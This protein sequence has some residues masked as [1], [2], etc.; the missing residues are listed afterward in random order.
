[1]TRHFSLIAS[2]LLT[3]LAVLAAK[4]APRP[5]SPAEGAVVYAPHPHFRWLRE[6][7]VKIDEVHCV[8]IARDEAFAEVVCEDHLEVVSR[9]VPVTALPPARYWW[10]VRRGDGDWSRATGFEVRAPGKTFTVRAGS[11]GETV[12]RMLLEAVKNAP[13]RVDFEPGEYAFSPDAGESLVTMTNARDL[14]I[15]GHGAHLVLAGTFLNLND[16]QRVTVQ[17]FRLTASRPGHTL[18]RVVKKDPDAMNLTVL[19]EPGHAPDVT[20]YFQYPGTAGSFLGC[21]DPVHHGKYIVGAFVSARNTQCTPGQDPPGSFV[22]NPVKPETLE[23]IPL[24][25]VAVVTAYRWHWVKTTRTD[26]CTFSD[27]TLSGL[28]GALCAGGG[29]DTAKSFLRC[30]VTRLEEKDY[31]GGHSHTGSGRIGEWIEGCVFECLADDGPAQQSFRRSIKGAEGLDGILVGGNDI[32]VGDRVSLVHA[33]SS[34]GV[35]AMVKAVTGAR[36]QLDRPISELAAAIGLDGSGDWSQVFLYCDARSNEDFVYR[37][38]RHV[39]GR[40]HGV[41]FNGTRAWIAENHFENLNGNAVL[42]GY[43]S[44]VSGHGAREVVVSGNSV[45]RCGWTPIEVWSTSG[46][47][48]DI[49]IRHN[50]VTEPRETAVVIK[51]CENVRILGNEFES[52]TSPKKGAWIVADR[53]EAVRVSDNLHPANVPLLKPDGPSK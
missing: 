34:R 27:L 30:R 2:L 19:P 9:F 1:M 53:A 21:M 5:E 45:R 13:A 43:T 44:E 51:G 48:G 22:F 11:D 6:A 8:Q 36:L 7:D 46:L 52:S 24:G 32:Q 42:A 49:L 50:R 47:G 37:R 17:H 4:D 10:R 35:S 29:K 25:A 28:P 23:S 38:N 20:S 12:R 18:V 3:R 15:D 16:C 26:E 33:K 40:A 14:I 31:F 41:K 39:G